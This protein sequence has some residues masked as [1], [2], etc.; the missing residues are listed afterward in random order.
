MN[1]KLSSTICGWL[2]NSKLPSTIYDWLLNSKLPYD[3]LLNSKLPST[4]YDWLL[5]SKLPY[6][7]SC[8]FSGEAIAYSFVF[9]LHFFHSDASCLESEQFFVTCLPTVSKN[10]NNNNQGMLNFVFKTK[11]QSISG[12]NTLKMSEL[13]HFHY[14]F[15]ATILYNSRISLCVSNP[16]RKYTYIFSMGIYGIN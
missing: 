2:L 5:N 4:I 9:F 8:L 6:S 1:S 13:Q 16:S 7:F 3:W 11:K 14:V 10:N 15:I 12:E